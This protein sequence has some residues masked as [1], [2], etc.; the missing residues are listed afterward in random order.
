MEVSVNTSFCEDEESSIN[1]KV[2]FT[3]NDFYGNSSNV[4]N[5]NLFENET[6]EKYQNKLGEASTSTSL[7]P[8]RSCE[9]SEL[10]PIAENLEESL[11]GVN[12]REILKKQSLLPP[13]HPIYIYA[14]YFSCGTKRI[15]IAFTKLFDVKLCIFNEKKFIEWSPFSFSN[16]VLQSE[17]I[18]KDI[19]SNLKNV[20]VIDDEKQIKISFKN[21]VR[22]ISFEDSF[23]NTKIMFTANEFDYFLKYRQCFFYSLQNLVFNKLNALAYYQ[24]YVKMCHQNNVKFLE[25]HQMFLFETESKNFHLDFLQLFSEIGVLL[26][27]QLERDIY[28]CSLTS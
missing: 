14:K 16:Y 8:N 21:N 3:V 6:K 15:V 24:K 27:D 18:V 28:F 13:I 5:Q 25:T 22:F 12:T 4:V 26:N 23:R 2:F 17:T 1:E 20:Y 9:K 7:G 19:L 11:I 10:F